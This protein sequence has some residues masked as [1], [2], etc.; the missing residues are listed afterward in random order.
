MEIY[1]LV[2]TLT[3]AQM[4]MRMFEKEGLSCRQAKSPREIGRG[5]CGYAVVLKN[6]PPDTVVDFVRRSGLPNFRIFVTRDGKNFEKI[7]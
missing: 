3:Y 4:V 7:G 2:R 5:G 1:V 6:A